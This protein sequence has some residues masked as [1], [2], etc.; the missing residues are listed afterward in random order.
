VI[1][2][3]AS[4]LYGAGAM[5]GVVNLLSRRPGAE[6]QRELLINRSMLG[7][8]DAVGF[9]AAPLTET[10]GLTLL[11]SGHWQARSDVDDDGWSDLPRYGRGVFRPRIFWDNKSGSHFFATVGTTIEEREGGTARNITLPRMAEPYLESLDTKR[12]DAGFVAQT[13][14]GGRVI[15]ARA[16][17]AHQHHDHR[18]GEIVERDRHQTIFAETAVRGTAGRQ[19]WV[20]GVA[21]ENDRYLPEDLRQFE[22]SYT[23]PGIFVQDDVEVTDWLSFSGSARFDD[24]SEYGSFFS[25]RLA[26]LLRSGQWNSRVSIGTGF[27][28]PSPITEET[29]AAGLSR[30]SIPMPLR[31]ERGRSAS[32]DVTRTAGPFSTTLTLFASRVKDPLQ[33]IREGGIELRNGARPTT[34]VGAE[35]LGTWRQEPFAVTATY[36]FVRAEEFEDGVKQDVALTPQHSAGIVAFWERDDV[37][38]MGAE[39][40]YTGVQRLETNPYAQRSEPYVVLGLLAERHFGRM[41]VFVNGENLTDVRQSRWQPLLRPDRAPDGRW[42]VDAWAPL[43]GRNI[44]AGIRLVF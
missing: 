18:F 26:A 10:W 24:H 1:K 33:A 32:L 15:S 23:T 3:V 22:Y 39:F 31:P 20:A 38:R 36:A 19:T 5:G 11:G 43:E 34:N 17:F 44:N 21:F 2:G 42:T 6:M 30:L 25:P 12:Y 40:Y 13:V 16:A 4:S 8:T 37:G 7:A 29:E 41:R 28:G 35:V 9:Y 27:F 14:R